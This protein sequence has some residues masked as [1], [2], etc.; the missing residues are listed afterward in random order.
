MA[1]PHAGSLVIISTG[2]H[3]CVGKLMLDLHLNDLWYVFTQTA[4]LSGM[5][6]DTTL[7]Y[8]Q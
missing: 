4:N 5:L 1:C 8:T 6:V 7:P 3:M 2:T